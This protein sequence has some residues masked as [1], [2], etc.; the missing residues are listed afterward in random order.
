M[1]FEIIFIVLI[2]AFMHAFWNAIVKKTNDK[3]IVI[4]LIALGHA[5][6]GLALLPIVSPPGWEALPFIIASIL[7]HWFYYYFLNYAYKFGDLSFVYPISRG[8]APLLIALGAFF[9]I[10]ENLPLLGWLG[11]LL[12]SFGII[13]ITGNLFRE[14][15][16]LGALIAA[17]FVSLIVAMYSLADGFGVRSSSSVFGYVAWLFSAEIIVVIYIFYTRLERLKAM[18]LTTRLVGL[19]AGILSSLAYALVLYAKTAAPLGFVS[20]LRETS[21][22]FAALIGVIWFGESPKKRRIIA[23]FVVTAGSVVIAIS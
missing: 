8:L 3:T 18:P 21:V 13:T 2:A 4:G 16:Q 9:Y 1:S 7:L 22:I 12:I 17:I 15:I 20:A 11:I 10:G 14:E 23:A 6:P 5:I 19:I